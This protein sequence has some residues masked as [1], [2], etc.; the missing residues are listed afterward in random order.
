MFFFPALIAVFLLGVGIAALSLHAKRA[1][2]QVLAAVCFAGVLFFAAQLTAKYEAAKYLTT[3]IGSP[4]FWVRVKF[5]IVALISP[6][7]VWLCFYVASGRYDNRRHLIRKMIPWVCLSCLL[8]AVAFTEG[9][10][11]SDSLP[12]RERY[13][14]LFTL[15]FGP[16]VIGQLAA[17]IASIGVAG[18]LTGLRRLEFQFIALPLGYLT[19][20]AVAI[21]LC[22][23]FWPSPWLHLIT[24]IVSYLVYVAFGISAWSVTSHRVY[25]RQQVLLTIWQ[26][27]MVVGPI[28]FS[29]FWLAS[30]IQ[31]YEDRAT[32]AA[33]AATVIGVAMLLAFALDDW[34]RTRF[35]MNAENRINEVSSQLHGVARK[36]SDPGVLIEHFEVVL[37]GLSKAPVRIL[38]KE[39]EEYGR[40]WEAVPLR[41]VEDRATLAE[42]WYSLTARSRVRDRGGQDLR[43][44]L[45]RKKWTALVFPGWE[46]SP[47]LILAVAERE[48]RLPFTFPELRAMRALANV[49]ESL[50]T[51]CRLALQARQAEQLAAIGKLGVSIAHELRNP[52]W[53][54]SSFSQLLPERV[55]DAE[56]LR[57]FAAIVPE[58]AKRIEALA[59]QLLD[60]ARPR[61]YNLVECDVHV[62]IEQTLT[63]LGPQFGEAGIKIIPRLEANNP[64]AVVDK[65]A[66]RQVLLNL[67]R[68]AAEAL[69]ANSV[70]QRIIEILT[71]GTETHLQIEVADNGPGIPDALRS[72]LFTAFAS[73]DKKAGLGLGLVV[74]KE[75]VAVH[76]GEIFASNPAN[77]GTRMT[78]VLPR[79][80]GVAAILDFD[81]T[82]SKGALGRSA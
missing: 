62:I 37:S 15:F 59:E 51:R 56:F 12:G 41:L 2:N 40:G 79:R 72:K 81:P 29:A 27:F 55:N 38:L 54:L 65:D 49:V 73:A 13:G 46:T 45:E 39:G 69:R 52:M 48:N 1:I 35:R 11:P 6:T 19:L 31:R 64:Q 67:T 8:A 16:M 44:F 33:A 53:T 74:C 47:T 71:K 10:K 25:H 61:E 20:V 63:L 32:A 3:G 68:N 78:V 26:R 34:I 77:G 23:A 43:E 66:I 21:E 14:P 70:E 36:Q 50:Y 30:I 17:C 5:A 24:R 80:T 28:A 9:F 42:G 57:N 4:L 58:E 18:K 82:G 7:L 22:H 60:L 75:I 76:S